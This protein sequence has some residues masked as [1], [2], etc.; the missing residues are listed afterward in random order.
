MGERKPRKKQVH[1][2]FAAL[3]Q[4]SRE[5]NPELQRGCGDFLQWQLP[6]TGQKIVFFTSGMGDGIFS[7]YWG[8]D[9]NG[10]VVSLVVP[11]MNPEYF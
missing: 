2:L 7:G 11:F 9:G 5:A 6:E 4:K 3:F 10:E 1:R 8:L